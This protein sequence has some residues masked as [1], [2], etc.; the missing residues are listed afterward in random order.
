[1]QTFLSKAGDYF[2][3]A[4]EMGPRLFLAKALR[5][6]GLASSVLRRTE[7]LADRR[8]MQPGR[9]AKIYDDYER[10]AIRDFAWQPVD[11]EG[12]RVL[13]IGCGSIGGLAPL[14]LV[15][16]AARYV[17]I[18]PAFAEDVYRHRRIQR[19]FLPQTIARSARLR[20]E[21]DLP[22]VSDLN[23]KAQ[24][25]KTPLERLVG[26]TPAD[27]VIS[28]SCLEHIWHLDAA[29]DALKKRT[30]G[31]TRH[32]HV[33]NFGN[34]RHRARPFDG[35]YE[36]PPERYEQAYGRAINRLRLPD[37]EAAFAR[38]GFVV[39]CAPFH[40][41]EE[42][43]PAAIDPWWTARYDRKMLAVRTALIFR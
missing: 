41:A 10:R 14:A 12:K 29:L 33:V 40:V 4:R 38:A 30:H 11:Y 27:V 20:D 9:L 3:A 17:G 25:L 22:S 18:D 37:M 7:T 34:H 42:A 31:G 24:F 19:D 16:G 2:R 36:M 23:A 15:E 21:T 8:Q 13:E 1:M 32:F 35:L 43:L 26:G 28:V 6:A 39:T 5:K